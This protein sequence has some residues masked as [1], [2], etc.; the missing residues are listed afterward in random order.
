M[1]VLRAVYQLEYVTLRVLVGLG[2]V[3]EDDVV[4]MIGRLF[5]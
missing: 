2:L 4:L 3:I 5:F 1:A